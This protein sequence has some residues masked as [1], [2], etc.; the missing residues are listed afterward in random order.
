MAD[1]TT[2]STESTTTEESAAQ[3]QTVRFCL[4]CGEQMYQ[5]TRYGLLCWICRNVFRRSI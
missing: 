1:K 4:I 5:G 3:T 2:A